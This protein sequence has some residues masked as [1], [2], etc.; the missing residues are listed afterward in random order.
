[1]FFIEERYGNEIMNKFMRAVGFSKYKTNRE[2]NKIFEAAHKESDI[3]VTFTGEEKDTF[4]E[5]TKMAGNGFGLTWS[6]S[7]E[8]GKPVC[9]YCY[10]IVKGEEYGIEESV[11]V[12]ERI[13]GNAYTG[14]FEDF[15]AGVLIIFFLQNGA[16]YLKIM[17]GAE[18]ERD[19]MKV[20]LSGLALDGTILLPLA[21]SEERNERR[22]RE[23]RQR[24]KLLAAAKQG[25]EKAMESLA[26]QDMN[27]YT[28]VSKR[29][30][31]EDIFSIVESSF[32]P[33]GT[34][35]DQYA[36][37]ADILQAEKAVN[38]FTKEKV[39]KL[40]LNYNG[41]LIDICINQQDL[42]GE[43]KEGRRFK[44]NIWLQGQLKQIVK[45]SSFSD[46]W[47]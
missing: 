40:K 15:R 37:V 11:C 32:M 13:I 24:I 41:I 25:D 19:K 46:V 18:G 3:N 45:K 12:E 36:I 30:L 4:F 5:L 22:V 20:A 7:I 43:P 26:Y 21:F 42:M 14:A 47:G 39:W 33:Y 34:E 44:G 16:D 6:G 10:P 38:L 35:C 29:M 9:E 27:I 23:Q 31:T 1:M 2:L 28:K 8:D 17:K